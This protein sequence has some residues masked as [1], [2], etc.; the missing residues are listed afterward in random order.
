MRMKNSRVLIVLSLVLGVSMAFNTICISKMKI[1]RDE[2]DIKD[3]LIGSF[4]IMQNRLNYLQNY[5]SIGHLYDGLV[6]NDRI[7][8]DTLKTANS[9]A[10]IVTDTPI[11]VF[12]FEE[13][14]C[15]NCI[16]FGMLKLENH[17]QEISINTV[18]FANYSE[19]YPFKRM[20]RTL[21][22]KR[23][24]IYNVTD[25]GELDE[26]KVPYF[27]IL[28]RDLSVED[29]FIP[30]KAFPEITNQYFEALK[31]KLSM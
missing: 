31:Q 17:F 27:F 20:S 23:L 21:N 14:Q 10:Q 11:L 3:S 12:R 6:L 9:L 26:L 25:L 22:R 2:I 15:Q 1:F 19:H 13:G 7:A 30:E 28:N 5:I 16:V 8:T 29:V 24:P 18:V 4:G